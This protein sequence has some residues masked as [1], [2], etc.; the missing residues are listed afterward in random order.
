MKYRKENRGS[1]GW[2]NSYDYS[3]LTNQSYLYCSKVNMN[4]KKEEPK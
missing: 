1:T 2:L 3:L 4:I